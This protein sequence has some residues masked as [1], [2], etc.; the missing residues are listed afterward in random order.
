MS[1]HTPVT[2]VDSKGQRYHQPDRIVFLNGNR[3]QVTHFTYTPYISDEPRQLVRI[4]AFQ[5]IKTRYYS[6]F[7]TSIREF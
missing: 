3:Y 7:V 5:G 6:G 1:L 2:C 4:E